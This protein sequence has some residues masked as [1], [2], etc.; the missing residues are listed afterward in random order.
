MIISDK[1]TYAKL[2]QL[3]SVAEEKLRRKI[4]PTFYSNSEWEKKQREE[5]NFVTQLIKQPKIFLIG[6][7]DEF[8]TFRKFS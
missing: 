3:L 2:F 7:E 1:L 6:T 8:I 4:N 5:N